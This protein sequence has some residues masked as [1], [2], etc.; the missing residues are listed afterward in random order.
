MTP[1]ENYLGLNMNSSK[2]LKHRNEV[3]VPSNSEETD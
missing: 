2:E 1:V 3:N